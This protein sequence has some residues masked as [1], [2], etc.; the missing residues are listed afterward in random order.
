[1]IAPIAKLARAVRERGWKGAMQQ[2][3]LIGDLKFGQFKGQDDFGNK[4]FENLEL[5]Y[6]QHRWVEYSNI[7]NYDAS[8]IPPE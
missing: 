4:Y 5:P 1:M 6:G 8:M 2:L 3:Y 7:H